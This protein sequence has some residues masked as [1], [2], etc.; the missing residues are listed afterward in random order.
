VYQCVELKLWSCPSLN[1]L[2]PAGCW[3]ALPRCAHALLS[4]S[5]S[6]P[7]SLSLSLSLS[8]S[9]LSVSLFALSVSASMR[10]CSTLSQL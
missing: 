7:L 8:V 9:P 2:T 6:S 10:S 4:R 1:R 5:S 3:D